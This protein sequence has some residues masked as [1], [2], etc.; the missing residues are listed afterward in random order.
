M[1]SKKI[2]DIE[3]LNTSL[4]SC[5]Y[6]VYIVIYWKYMSTLREETPSL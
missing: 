2:S 3:I 1:I 4:G 6:L 5:L